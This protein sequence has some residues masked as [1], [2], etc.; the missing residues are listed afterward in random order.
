M[1]RLYDE[2][3]VFLNASVWTT[4]RC[5]V[6]EAFAAGLPV[7]STATGDIAA[8]VRD[9]ETGRLVPPDDPAAMAR[10][11]IELLEHPRAPRRHGQRPRGVTS[12][13]S[14]GP[15]CASAGRRCTQREP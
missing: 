13:G 4:S 9:G 14:P 11:V 1:P 10:A 3:D 6:L 15:R 12:S 2:A 8:M 7:V 5:R